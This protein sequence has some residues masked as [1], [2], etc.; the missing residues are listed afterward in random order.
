RM[1]M[2]TSPAQCRRVVSAL[3]AWAF[4]QRSARDG[5]PAAAPSVPPERGLP[6]VYKV[7]LLTSRRAGGGE[8]G[9]FPSRN[10]GDY[11]VTGAPPGAAP[12]AE[13]VLPAGRRR[14][15]PCPGAGG[16]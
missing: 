5:A 1:R 14:A 12:P 9:E 2:R 11:P 4:C 3:G 8:P 16:S 6:L 15:A 13:T 10:S 7:I